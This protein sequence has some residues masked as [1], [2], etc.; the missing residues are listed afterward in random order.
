MIPARSTQVRDG[1]GVLGDG[2]GLPDFGDHPAVVKGVITQ[3]EQKEDDHQ[4]DGP[5]VVLKRLLVIS[6]K[7]TRYEDLCPQQDQRQRPPGDHKLKCFRRFVKMGGDE[8]DTE[9]DQNQGH[10]KEP[11]RH[12]L[13]V[14]SSS[15]ASR[16]ADTDWPLRMV[17][18]APEALPPAGGTAVRLFPSLAAPAK[19]TVCPRPGGCRRR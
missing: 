4:E 11:T 5:A 16:R 3:T 8:A 6:G 14:H 2:D 1:A 13:I 17:W 15:A 19:R 7:E 9:K 12:C 18:Q 10:G